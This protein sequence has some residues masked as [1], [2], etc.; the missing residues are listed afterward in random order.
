[1]AVGAGSPVW[2]AME[3]ED[4]LKYFKMGSATRLPNGGA[5]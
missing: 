1:M 2:V 3:N 5:L 4:I